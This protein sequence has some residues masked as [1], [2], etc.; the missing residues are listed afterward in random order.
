MALTVSERSRR[1]RIKNPEAARVSSR[2][3]MRRRR[4]EDPELYRERHRR[5]AE[6]NP[7]YA[8]RRVE[9]HRDRVRGIKESKPCADCGGRFHF[10]AMDF[11]HVSGEKLACVSELLNAPWEKILAEIEKCDLVCANCHRV[12]S[13]EREPTGRR[14]S[15]R[16]PTSD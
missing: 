13:W 12:R 11:D 3:Y 9:D 6:E 14:S 4:A 10:S 5:W 7:E 15:S 1:Y 8:R 2:A 16:G